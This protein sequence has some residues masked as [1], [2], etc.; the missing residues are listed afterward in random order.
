MSRSTILRCG[1]ALGAAVPLASADV[2]WHGVAH[3]PNWG[4]PLAWDQMAVPG[5]SDTARLSANITL[6]AMSNDTAVIRR[7]ILDDTQSTPVIDLLGRTLQVMDGGTWKWG[8][9]SNTDTDPGSVD[10][11]GTMVLSGTDP[12]VYTAGPGVNLNN[13][14]IIE[15]RGAGMLTVQSYYNHYT[16]EF[17]GDGEI[18]NSA[19]TGNLMTNDGVTRKTGGTGVSTIEPEFLNIG[20]VE[21]QSGTLLIQNPIDIDGSTLT[22][23]NWTARNGGTLELDAMQPLETNQGSL[24]LSRS[25]SSIIVGGSPIEDTLLTNHAHLTVTGDRVFTNTLHNTLRFWIGAGSIVTVD[26][27][28]DGWVGVTGPTGLAVIDGDVT[29]GPTGKFDISLGGTT[30]ETEHDVIEVTGTIAADNSII[31]RPAGDFDPLDYPIGTR[32]E[33]VRAP[34]ITGAFNRVVYT[35]GGS[36]PTHGS[37]SYFDVVHETE[38]DGTDIVVAVIA[39]RGCLGADLAP[40]V[41]VLDLSD[42]NTFVIAFYTGDP[43][44]DIAE[45]IGVL[46]LADVLRFIDW[47]L[48]GCP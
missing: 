26:I 42:I 16:H 8:G 20:E 47:F 7:L 5:E 11:Y 48:A 34:E 15:H 29:F 32:F 37:D 44:A 39:H 46:D 24:T 30:P 45:P 14:W 40:P 12:T 27:T 35:E 2:F 17:T 33:V 36:V 31:V 1:L 22:G 41:G 3:A 43:S 21:V 13:H 18:A 28:N 4:N 10:L 9:F 19:A 38:P 25:T 23:G 6:G